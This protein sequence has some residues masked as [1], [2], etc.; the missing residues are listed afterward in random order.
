MKIVAAFLVCLASQLFAEVSLPVIKAANGIIE[1]LTDEQKKLA[2]FA[3]D[4]DERENWHYVPLERQGIRLDALNEEQ[5]Q[6]AHELLS[7][8]LSAEGHTT[9]KEVIQ[10]E[11]MLYEQ[12]DKSEFRNPGKYTVAIFG[13][14]SKEKPWGWR[15]EGHHLSLNFTVIS[16]KVTLTTPFFFG[17]NPAE[18]REGTLK[19]LRPL[20]TIEDAARKLAR[21]IHGEGQ[22][23][24]FTNEPPREILTGQDRTAKTLA[25]EGVLFSNLND[26]HKNGLL[27][28]VKTIAAKQ[29]PEFLSI[30]AEKLTD[31]QL[32]WAGEFE[33]GEP[34]YFRIQTSDFLIEYA[35][36]QNKANH[37]HLVW[38]DFKN[39]FGRDL[40]KEHLE[41]SH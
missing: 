28:L 22:H 8:S 2:L 33:K 20:G 4:A 21:A 3:L 34:H 25:K 23:V 37:A 7:H 14:P 31:A 6:A 13:T 30:T 38:R 15:F 24:R 16:D 27:N 5:Q 17:T 11:N 10:L 39:D 26:E 41:H 32:A 40:L 18:V 35:N 29:R 36:T 19:G 12:S 1:K 9:A